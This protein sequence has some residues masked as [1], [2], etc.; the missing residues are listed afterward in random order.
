MYS[1]CVVCAGPLGRNESIEHFPVGTRLAFDAAKGFLWVVCR[2]CERWNLT[3]LEERWEAIEECEKAYR[4]T[5]VRVATDQIGLARLP[6]GTELVR[7]GRPLKPEMAAWRYGDQFGRRR[8]RALVRGGVIGAA[9]AGGIAAVPMM[10][11]PVAALGVVGLA[12]FQTT[13]LAGVASGGGAFM[14]SRWLRDDEGRWLLVAGNDVASVRIRPDEGG[15]WALR[16]PY[17]MRVDDLRSWRESAGLKAEWSLSHNPFPVGEANVGGEAGL[18]IART[19]LPRI[20]GLGGNRELVRDAVSALGDLGTGAAAFATAAARVREIGMRQATGDTGALAHLP[21]EVRLA[22]EMAAFE[23]Q[24]RLALEG[25]L[26]ALE[27]AW[28]EAEELAGIADQLLE[29]P[30]VT[31]KLDALKKRR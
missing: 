1:A 28:K 17:I 26:S 13:I 16:V 5:R 23:D 9:V 21:R 3:P 8:R 15:R 31:A 29:P 18:T 25:E 11:I 30:A 12:L 4:D 14:G 27:R 7:V 20:N 22:L 2:R 24:E 19:L 6:D 10:G